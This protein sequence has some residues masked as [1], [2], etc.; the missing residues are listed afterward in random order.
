MGA[1]WKEGYNDSGGFALTLGISGAGL[2]SSR[3]TAALSG[4]G[5]GAVSGFASPLKG[6]DKFLWRAQ[7]YALATQVAVGFTNMFFQQSDLNLRVSDL[8]NQLSDIQRG[9]NKEIENCK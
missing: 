7:F 4:N 1:V 8:S 5:S 9:F 6:A 3:A 2:A